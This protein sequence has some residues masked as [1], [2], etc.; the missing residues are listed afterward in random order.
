M[1]GTPD[2]KTIQLTHDEL[3]LLQDLRRATPE[4]RDL[5]TR[6]IEVVTAEN[7]SKNKAN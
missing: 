3:K 7:N 1:A 2:G 6:L 5:V 4:I